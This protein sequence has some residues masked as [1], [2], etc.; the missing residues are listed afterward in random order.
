MSRQD[1]LAA[2]RDVAAFEAMC[3]PY[4]SLAH[5]LACFWAKKALAAAG[6]DDEPEAQ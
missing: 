2:Q 4:A 1:L 5:Y 6:T 3:H